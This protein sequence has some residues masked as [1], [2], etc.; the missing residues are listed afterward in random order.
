M[1]LRCV[2]VI[3][4]ENVKKRTY[5]LNLKKSQHKN[6]LNQFLMVVWILW[7]KIYESNFDLFVV[8][9]L[10]YFQKVKNIIQ[11]KRGNSLN[12]DRISVMRHDLDEL[13]ENERELDVLIET[14]KEISKK[15]IDNNKFAYVTCTD[16]H[17]I[18]MYA[19]QM[20]MVVKAPPDSQL[21]LL[22]T[23]GDPPPF[24]LK[25]E[26]DEIDIFFC[27]DST[28]TGGL[29]PAVAPQDSTDSEDESS[30]RK[31]RKS[32]TASANKRRSLGSAQRNLNKEFDRMAPK[33]RKSKSKLFSEFNATVC[34]ESSVDS[35]DVE[36]LVSAHTSS[37]NKDLMINDQTSSNSL[38]PAF[39]IQKDVKLPFFS[40]QKTQSNATESATTWTDMPTVSELLPTSFSFTNDDPSSGFYSIEPEVEYDYL[41][42]ETEGI[43]DLFDF[44]M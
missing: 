38:E 21:G 16:L 27:P 18:D 41:L 43:M 19:D 11:W 31:H 10:I 6:N 22:D 26:K 20:I 28:N 39:N 23:E 1:H 24:Y 5:C 12:F 29:H 40:P 9:H 2:F 33:D 13:K 4:S 3:V 32:L 34:Q 44:T 37:N 8:F 14:L 7:Q 25:S 15:D 42:A 36:D 30:V 17:N 35:V